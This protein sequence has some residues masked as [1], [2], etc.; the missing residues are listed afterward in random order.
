MKKTIL[1]LAMSSLNL[2][3]LSSAY[4]ATDN[5]VVTAAVQGTD[6]VQMTNI[7]VGTLDPGEAGIITGWITRGITVIN[8]KSNSDT[9]YKV[10][11]TQDTQSGHTAPITGDNFYL[12]EA[13]GSQD[14]QISF[15]LVEGTTPSPTSASEPTGTKLKQGSKAFD[16]ATLNT[17]PQT[18]IYTF[19]AEGNQLDTV[20][21]GSYTTILTA[22]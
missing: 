5:S 10:A 2:L 7:C 19:V 11:V 8:A 4:A 12:Y 18:K 17:A 15:Y 22:N 14:D 6:E 1:S 3:F 13:S 9:G 21:V 20:S 16:F